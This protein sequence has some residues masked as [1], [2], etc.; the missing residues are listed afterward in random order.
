MLKAIK[1]III[2]LLVCLVAML[3]LAVVF[4]EYIPARKVVPEVSTYTVPDTVSQLLADDIDNKDS[5]VILT[6]EEGE[7][8]VTSKD[9]NNYEAKNEYVPGKANP[10]GPI[11]EEVETQNTTNTTSSSANTN[12]TSKDSNDS[13][14]TTDS[15]K[16]ENTDTNESY[17]NNKGTK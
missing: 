3:L 16:N 14:N 13:T 2:M 1:E 12:T 7:Y 5:N 6:F 15:S 9:L 17:I 8:E 11:I 10:F 4:Y